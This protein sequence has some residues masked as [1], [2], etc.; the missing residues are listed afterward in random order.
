MMKQTTS[1]SLSACGRVF[2]RLASQIVVFPVLSFLSVVYAINALAI[3]LLLQLCRSRTEVSRDDRNEEKSRS[4]RLAGI[5]A[6]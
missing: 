6:T 4:W 2:S 1:L 3:L 5:V